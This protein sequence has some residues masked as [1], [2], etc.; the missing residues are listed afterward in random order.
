M[1]R[2]VKWKARDI[3]VNRE[4]A[5]SFTFDHGVKGVGREERGLKEC[6]RNGFKGC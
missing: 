1:P 6:Q 4:E 5:Q 3:Q 2:K